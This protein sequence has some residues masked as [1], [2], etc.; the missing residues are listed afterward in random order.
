[1]SRE[2]NDV[3]FTRRLETLLES[4]VFGGIEARLGALLFLTGSTTVIVLSADMTAY[5][6]QQVRAVMLVL[7]LAIDLVLFVWLLAL[8]VPTLDPG[9]RARG[10]GIG[11]RGVAPMGAVHAELFAD[12]GRSAEIEE[13]CAFADRGP[14]PLIL[15]S[16]APGSGKTSLLA[17]GVLPSLEQQSSRFHPVYIAWTYGMSGSSVAGK[18]KSALAAAGERRCIVALDECENAPLEE[19]NRLLDALRQFITLHSFNSPR[20]I[21]ATDPEH[22]NAQRL[23]EWSGHG[24]IGRV[25]H[26]T[27]PPF[28]AEK[29]S[30]IIGVLA[31]HCGRAL[32]RH[33]IKELLADADPDKQWHGIDLCMILA[34]LL[35]LPVSQRGSSIEER[36]LRAMLARHDL[37]HDYVLQCVGDT[38]LASADQKRLILGLKAIAQ[39]SGDRGEVDGME[40]Q[41]LRALVQLDERSMDDVMAWLSREDVRVVTV[42]ARGVVRLATPRL[43]AAL[44]RQRSR[45]TVEYDEAVRLIRVSQRAWSVNQQSRVLLR[46]KELRKLAPFLSRIYNEANGASARVFVERSHARLRRVQLSALAAGAAVVAGAFIVTLR[47]M[48]ALERTRAL[49]TTAELDR[50]LREA[51]RLWPAT[52]ANEG[53]ISRWVADASELLEIESPTRAGDVAVY[54]SVARVEARVKELEAR[55]LVQVKSEAELSAVLAD[56]T[57]VLPIWEARR[58]WLQRMLRLP[59]ATW[60][61]VDPRAIQMD[62]R[63]AGLDCEGLNSE[64]WRIVDPRTAATTFGQEALALAITTYALTLCTGADSLGLRDTHAW[65]LYRNGRL[66]EALSESDSVV[67]ASAGSPLEGDLLNSNQQ[68]RTAVAAWKNQEVLAR[69]QELDQLESE[70]RQAAIMIREGAEKRAFED[71]TDEQLYRTLKPLVVSLKEFV[72]S[73]DGVY[74]YG[75]SSRHGWGMLRRADES[76]TLMARTVTDPR[77]AALWESA[78]KYIGDV[79]S[80]YK[81]LQLTPQ[82]GLLPLGPDPVSTLYEFAHVQSGAVPERESPS[83]QIVPKNDMCIVLVLI[84]GGTFHMGA[85]SSDVNQP[86]FVVGAGEDEKPTRRVGVSPFF[87]SKVEMTQG[88]WMHLAGIN[89]A[90]YTERVFEPAHNDRGMPWSASYPVENVSWL[91]FSAVLARVELTLPTEAQWEYCAREGGRS[92]LEGVPISEYANVFDQYADEHGLREIG[93]IPEPLSDHYTRSAPVGQFMPNAWGLYDLFG[94]V[95]EFTR[96]GYD[97]YVNARAMLALDPHVSARAL[98]AICAKGGSYYSIAYYARPSFRTPWQATVGTFETGVRPARRIMP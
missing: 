1:M 58:A 64:A 56:L 7:L 69:R 93:K 89:P 81:G 29:A 46:Y 94:N 63:Y 42:D 39:L 6:T 18:I 41:T 62:P 83:V 37:F 33:A 14:L 13:L 30:I 15:L 35:R 78:L 25:E 23:R 82:V 79:N 80:P 50:L 92:R 44:A 90:Y 8:I 85:Q 3:A 28:S 98:T 26:V 38:R 87:M 72:S 54:S 65:A 22:A 70:L 91:G 57:A 51:S 53:E 59:S 68:L 97:P 19:W 2:S 67:N 66:D 40:R 12:L 10:R 96:D 36:S 86:N 21:V 48:P 24:G 73:S 43:K 45:G 88:Q 49:A 4:V 60:P 9:R 5:V 95:W 27:L 16:G 11:L 61:I 74:S 76:A 55:S 84:P 17:A 20:L 34:L 31:Q 52:S 77:A 71:A 47:V 75:T 32:S